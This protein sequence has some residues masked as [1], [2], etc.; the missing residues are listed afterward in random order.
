MRVNYVKSARK[1]KGERKCGRCGKAIEVGMAYRYAE[2]RYGPKMIRCAEC[3]TFRPS[4]LTGSKIATAYA[5]QEAA[6]DTLN[7]LDLTV[8][9]ESDDDEHEHREP[10]EVADDV[11]AL[12]DD[13]KAAL[14]ECADG[15]EECRDDYQDGFDSMPEGLQQGD[16]GQQV[17]ERIDAL[18]TWADELRGFDPDGWDPDEGTSPDD[19]LQDVLSEAIDL[20]NNLEV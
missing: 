15:A 4:E 3:P 10:S 13:I 17:E 14:E 7:G 9:T 8:D 12:V 18:D 19:Y 16:T 11:Q 5:A 2:P 20:V 6:E 1:A